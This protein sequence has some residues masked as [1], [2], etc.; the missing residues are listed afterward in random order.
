MPWALDARFRTAVNESIVAFI[1]RRQPSAHSDVASAL[2]ESAR[3]LSDVSW[4][5]PDLPRY[6]YVVL[7]TPDYTIFGIAF[8]M[9][10]VAYRLPSGVIEEGVAAGGTL[11]PAMGDGWVRFKPWGGPVD[12]RR[13]CKIAHDH[14]VGPA[15][16]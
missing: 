15:R 5:C 14:S 9:D 16:P 11:E 1:E 7:H 8:G 12:L 13:W 10:A 6:A 4:Y 2:T 3:H